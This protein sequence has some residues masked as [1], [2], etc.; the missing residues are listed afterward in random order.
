MTLEP[1]PPKTQSHPQTETVCTSYIQERIKVNL[2]W[3]LL[4][5]YTVDPRLSGCNGTR[6]LPDT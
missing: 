2:G 5:A 4:Q 6:P 1:H 3:K